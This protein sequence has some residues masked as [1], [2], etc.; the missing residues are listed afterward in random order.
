MEFLVV[1]SF[2]KGAVVIDL[3]TLSVTKQSKVFFFELYLITKTILDCEN[4]AGCQEN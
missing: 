4:M 1:N 2:T 3:Q